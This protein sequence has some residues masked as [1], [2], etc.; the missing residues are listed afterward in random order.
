MCGIG[1]IY[2]HDYSKD[3]ARAQE[4]QNLLFDLRD[5]GKHASGFAW[6][7]INGDKALYYKAP[8]DAKHF[9]RTSTIGKKAG[10]I[11]RFIML[12]TRFTTQGSTRNNFNNHPIVSQNLLVTHNGVISNYDEP[13]QKFKVARK[14]QVDSESINIALKHG[15][16][17]YTLDTIRG[18]MSVAWVDQ[19]TPEIVNLMTNGRN[20]LVIGTTVCGRTV[21]A[22]NAYHLEDNFD[23]IEIYNAEPFTQYILK[24]EGVVK[25]VIVEGQFRPRVMGRFDHRAVF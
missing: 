13:S 6:C 16:V 3:T 18:S 5:R 9:V 22:S 25:K 12:H 15:G 7:P 11:N 14:G 8:V 24:P 2:S 19:N 1:G 21:W 4:A 23:L 20:P 10:N 17:A